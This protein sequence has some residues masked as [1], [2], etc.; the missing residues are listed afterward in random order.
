M[1]VLLLPDQF[2]LRES[3]LT[4]QVRLDPASIL[5]CFCYDDV[6]F[7]CCRIAVSLAE[8]SVKNK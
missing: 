6:V 8:I 5:V 1:T 4:V 7:V 3:P 2:S